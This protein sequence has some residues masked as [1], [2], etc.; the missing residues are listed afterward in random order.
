MKMNTKKI[1]LSLLDLAPITEGHSL[2][3]AFTNSVRLARQVGLAGGLTEAQ[4]CLLLAM[5]DGAETRASATRTPNFIEQ[6]F[7]YFFK[8]FTSL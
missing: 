6:F 4:A 1:P 2:A 7:Y 8:H 3:D 5:L